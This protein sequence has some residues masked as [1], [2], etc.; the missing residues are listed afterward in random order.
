MSA[1]NVTSADDNRMQVDSLKKGKRKGKGKNQHQRG[2]RTT[3]TSSTDIITCK[4]CGIPGHWAKDCWNPGGGAHDN[5]ASN[6]SNPQ[7]GKGH[8]KGKGKGKHVDVVETNR[9][10]ET[11]SPAT[12]NSV[13]SFTSTEYNWR[14]LVHFKRGTVAGK[15]KSKNTGKGKGKH[16]D[17]VE[18]EHLQPSETASTVSY[19]SQDLSVVGEISCIS[20]VDPWIMGVTLNSVSSTRRQ[21]GAEYLLLDSGPLTYQDTRSRYLILEYTQQVEQDYNTTED[22]W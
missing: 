16:V 5:S 3:N 21:A 8:K 19:L 4:N 14:T 1:G 6:N 22:D 2:N 12:F 10:S 18:T 15:G 9:P 11:A 17:V 13:V 7:K 20:S